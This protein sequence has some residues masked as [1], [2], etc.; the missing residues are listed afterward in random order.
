VVSAGQRRSQILALIEAGAGVRVAELS[1][2]YRVSTMTIRRDLDALH[3]A[4]TLTRVRGGALRA[5]PD[6]GIEDTALAVTAVGLVRPGL[7]VALVGTDG[8]V[9]LAHALRS[10]PGLTVLTNSVEVADVLSDSPVLLTGG[11]RERRGGPLV[12][13]LAVAALHGLSPDLLL[14]GCSGFDGT[15]AGVGH[16]AEAQT[17]AAFVRA[18]RRTVLV[19]DRTRFGAPAFARFAALTEIDTLVTDAVP[20]DVG[21]VVRTVVPGLAA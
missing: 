20:T 15:G 5:V 18:S 16:L 7:T 19:A 8:T 10:V 4:G 1:D 6:D 3:R 21:G 11:S 13:P 14:V 17:T 12:G 9:A 2:R